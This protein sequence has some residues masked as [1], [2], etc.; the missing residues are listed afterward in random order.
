VRLLKDFIEKSAKR[1]KDREDAKNAPPYQVRRVNE[2]LDSRRNF[3]VR[4]R[5]QNFPMTMA[6]KC[7]IC[8]D[9]LG[10]REQLDQGYPINFRDGGVRYPSL[11]VMTFALLLRL[12]E[13]C[14]TKP[15]STA[16]FRL[17]VCYVVNTEL[18]QIFSQCWYHFFSS[19]ISSPHYP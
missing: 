12:A 10:L 9:E 16:I 11:F 13:D 2:L 5:I 18:I 17:L 15:R 1:V 8:G 19:D 4:K 14:F 7:A 3:M 6:T